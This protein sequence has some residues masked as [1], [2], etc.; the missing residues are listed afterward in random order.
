LGIQ[1]RSCPW[2]SETCQAKRKQSRIGFHF[3]PPY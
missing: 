2:K 3:V 1:D